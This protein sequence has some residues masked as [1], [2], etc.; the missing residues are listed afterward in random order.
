MID[1][2]A[3]RALIPEEEE[4]VARLAERY[5][6]LRLVE[7]ELA[8][9]DR[10]R[11]RA[12]AAGNG[13]RYSPSELLDLHQ[14]GLISARHVRR[15]L[16]LERRSRA[17]ARHGERPVAMGWQRPAVGDTVE[18]LASEWW[19]RL[20][21]AL[22]WR[23]GLFGLGMVLLPSAA[24][25]R[26]SQG[27]RLI[28]ELAVVLALLVAVLF[29]VAARLWASR[30]VPGSA[31]RV[32]LAMVAV[33]IAYLLPTGVLAMVMLLAVVGLAADAVA[34]VFWWRRAAVDAR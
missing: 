13:S 14:A 27:S 21:W 32:L 19:T 23:W 12:A 9:L 15:M 3:R 31:F 30:R 16:G 6:D 11:G 34:S 29:G 2:T 33:N 8:E 5:G 18:R 10:L 28:V 25:I 24:Q 17:S 4:A 7:L 22:V 26:A 20:L 1:R